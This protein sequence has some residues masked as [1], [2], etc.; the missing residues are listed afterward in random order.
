MWLRLLPLTSHR[1][2]LRRQI[3]I[4]F[5]TSADPAKGGL[6]DRLS[7]PNVLIPVQA[8]HHNEMMSPAVTE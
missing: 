8:A 7:R 1:H 3:P 6:V 4:V 2:L 5:V